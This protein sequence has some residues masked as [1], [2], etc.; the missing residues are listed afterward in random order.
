MLLRSAMLASALLKAPAP[1]FNPT[2]LA[3]RRPSIACQH[4]R[5]RR[6]SLRA[7]AAN[8]PRLC[9]VAHV[10]VAALLGHIWRRTGARYGPHQPLLPSKGGGLVR[11]SP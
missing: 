11:C 6:L 4:R 10:L 1:P 2:R 9:A 8:S 3:A 7:P 5:V